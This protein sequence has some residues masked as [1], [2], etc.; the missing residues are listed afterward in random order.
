MLL[1][2][3]EVFGQA[4]KGDLALPVAE[5][6]AEQLPQECRAHYVLTKCRAQL[7]DYDA[8]KASLERTFE[9]SSTDI[10]QLALYDPQLKPLWRNV[11]EA[12]DPVSGDPLGAER[13]DAVLL[14][15]QQVVGFS[16]RRTLPRQPSA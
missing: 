11:G 7:G 14:Q 13:G 15:P 10:R 8:A 2:R 12:W 9:H 6:L 5:T 1:A 4:G 16:R 3:C